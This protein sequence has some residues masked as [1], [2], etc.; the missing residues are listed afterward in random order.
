MSKSQD[1]MIDKVLK[2]IYRGAIPLAFTGALAKSIISNGSAS[3]LVRAVSGGSV[4]KSDEP[5][6]GSSLNRR[7]RPQRQTRARVIPDINTVMRPTIQQGKLLDTM[8]APNNQA[9]D[10]NSSLKYIIPASALLAGVG[11]YYGGDYINKF[12]EKAVGSILSNPMTGEIINKY[13]IGKGINDN[14]VEEK[15]NNKNYVVPTSEENIIQNNVENYDNLKKYIPSSALIATVSGLYL[16]NK[17]MPSSVSVEI[18]AFRSYGDEFII[19]T[20]TAYAG[21]GK[22]KRVFGF[23]NSR[24]RSQ[25]LAMSEY[26]L[27]PTMK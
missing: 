7:N 2:G 26:D 19:G 5:M 4:M 21:L 22:F 17:Y 1:T 15:I 11:A 18:P 9:G 20:R 8:S 27:L 3:A 25:N 14:V 13:L 16:A 10:K 23:G 6:I 12:A 24:E